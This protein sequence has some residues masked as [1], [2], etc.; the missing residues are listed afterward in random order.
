MLDAHVYVANIARQSHKHSGL[1]LKGCFDVC[2]IPRQPIHS[3]FDLC[4]GLPDQAKLFQN[5]I[6][7]LSHPYTPTHLAQ[8]PPNTSNFARNATS[9]TQPSDIG[10][11]TFQPSRIS[12]S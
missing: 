1:S 8:N 5:Q 2:Q 7:N 3:V 12:W 11:N 9:T 6:L 10:R 4:E